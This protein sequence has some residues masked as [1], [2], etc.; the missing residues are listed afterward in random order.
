MIDNNLMEFSS[1]ISNE[2]TVSVLA[3]LSKSIVINPGYE[4]ADLRMKELRDSS[5]Q[6]KKHN[7]NIG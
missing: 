3:I 4:R 1:H 6:M 7:I 2:V 5:S